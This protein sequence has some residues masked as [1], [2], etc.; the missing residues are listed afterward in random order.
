MRES[1]ED[2]DKQIHHVHKLKSV[3]TKIQFP[4]IDV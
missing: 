3:I 4:Q 2:L 1:K